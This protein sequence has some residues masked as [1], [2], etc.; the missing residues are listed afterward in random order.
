MVENSQ[1][2]PLAA[3]LYIIATPIG[4][5]T[6]ITLRALDVLGKVDLIAC[7]D[8]RI[9]AKLAS[10]Y[11]ISAPKVAYHEH[12][13]DDVRPKIISE[14]ERG[15]R[16]ALISD[17]GTPLVS[18]PGYKLVEECYEKGIY[19]TTLPGAS[20]PMTALVLSGLP[21]DRFM[22]AGFLPPK[23]AARRKVYAEL[24]TIPATL[25]FFETAPRLQ[26]SLSDAADILGDRPAAVAR[27]LTKKFEE[28]KRGT[29]SELATY[30]R[31]NGQ[32]KGEIVLVI[33]RGQPKTK[34]DYTQDEIDDLIREAL[35]QLN[36]SIKD[37]SAYV[38]AETGM[39]KREV[40]ARA[41]ALGTTK[42]R[43]T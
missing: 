25:I 18:D 7:E 29:L 33:G 1:T 8:T 21:T 16:V 24:V 3:G 34:Q 43:S 20:A 10:L 36:M 5:I 14:I 28:I 23:S 26:E 35:M 37:A 38:A 15:G 31:E 22:F 30:Y 17:A 19:V 2:A 27:E 12:N 6:D 41:L 40:Y 13:A 42:N 11:D 39:K 4:N 9:S 32:P